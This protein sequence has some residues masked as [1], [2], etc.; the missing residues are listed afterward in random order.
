MFCVEKGRG[1]GAEWRGQQGAEELG[2]AEG[3]GRAPVCGSL[4]VHTCGC[5]RVSVHVHLCAGVWGLIHGMEFEC[6]LILADQSLRSLTQ[7]PKTSK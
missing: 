4:C 7:E 2:R 3:D 5:L 6:S 1:V